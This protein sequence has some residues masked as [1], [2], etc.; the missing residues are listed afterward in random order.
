MVTPLQEPLS[1]PLQS[2]D[3]SALMASISR[4][5]RPETVVM[6]LEMCLN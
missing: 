2:G 1:E 6:E 5:W 4:F 3:V